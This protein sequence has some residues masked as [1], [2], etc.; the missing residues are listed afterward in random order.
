M[1][2]QGMKFKLETIPC[3]KLK[4]QSEGMVVIPCAHVL[5]PGTARKGMAV[6]W[7]RGWVT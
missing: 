4:G 6:P 1:S 2:L 3:S 7:S 5:C